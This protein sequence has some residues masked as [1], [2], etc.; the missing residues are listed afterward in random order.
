MKYIFTYPAQIIYHFIRYLGALSLLLYETVCW[1]FVPPFKGERILCQMMRV[2]PGSFFIASLIS[3]FMG[4]IMA[5]QM[6]SLMV[7]MNAEI[8]IPSIVAISLTRELAPVLTSLIVA[9]R[10]GAGITAELGSMVVTEQVDALKA[11][12]VNPVKYLVVPRFLALIIMLP[13]LTV[14]ADIIGIVGGFLI[15]VFK[16]YINPALYMTMVVQALEIRDVSTGLI[17]TLMFGVV[18]AMVGCYEGLNIRGGSEGVG[19]ATT[20]SVVISFILIIMVDCV[21]TTMFY[22]IFGV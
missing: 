3:L 2:G 6:A 19:K 1:I 12:A 20:A 11:F 4:M 16:L 14:F 7:E 22:F 8:Y 21:F 18:I 10:I 9:G 17:K 5:L 15:C 13:L